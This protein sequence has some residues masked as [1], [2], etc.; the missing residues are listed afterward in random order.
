MITGAVVLV[1]ATATGMVLRRG[2]TGASPEPSAPAVVPALAATPPAS[3]VQADSPVSGSVGSPNPADAVAALQPPKAES[4]VREDLPPPLAPTPAQPIDRPAS[5]P[6]QASA[7]A[8]APAPAPAAL[9]AE[10]VAPPPED[11]AVAPVATPDW[12]AKA[13][14]VLDRAMAGDLVAAATLAAPLPSEIRDAVAALQTARAALPRLYVA[15]QAAL[16]AAG[17]RLPSMPDLPGMR[18]AGF[19]DK[20]VRFAAGEH[21]GTTLPWDRLAQRDHVVLR[22]AL[23]AAPLTAEQRLLLA[24]A[25][26]DASTLALADAADPVVATFQR[27][28]R[29]KIEAA[30]EAERLRAAERARTALLREVGID[31]T[32]LDPRTQRLL[33]SLSAVVTREPTVITEPVDRR[34]ELRDFVIIRAD[35]TMVAGGELIPIPGALVLNGSSKAYYEAIEVPGVPFVSCSIHA[36]QTFSPHGF[37]RNRTFANGV[38]YGNVLLDPAQ[39]PRFR[40]CAFIGGTTT[41]DVVMWEKTQQRL[42]QIQACDFHRLRLR[43]AR[44]IAASDRCAFSACDLVGP[45]G[46][47]VSGDIS[48]WDAK[49]ALQAQLS[50]RGVPVRIRPRS[51][52]EQTLLGP[53]VAAV[54]KVLDR[55]VAVWG[56]KV[57]GW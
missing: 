24:R 27:L 57:L 1:S 54:T 29:L 7:P 13:V 51:G 22:A 21:A 8:P 11:Q 49:G 46:E 41:R 25:A 48:A 37:E 2:S 43:S 4:T 39:S 26:L 34:I 15:Q 36:G 38:F 45:P 47:A 33:A 30:A 44:P 3:A 53:D 40:E 20:G 10:A 35:V 12:T 31:L 5:A 56:S 9:P 17:L 23:A 52:P 55:V 6:D 42:G 28:A 19:S 32:A 50:A 18:L 14:D 16:V